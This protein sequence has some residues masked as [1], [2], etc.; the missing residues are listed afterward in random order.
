MVVVTSLVVATLLA[1]LVPVP[2]CRTVPEAVH[3]R[4]GSEIALVWV[5]PG[6]YD[7]LSQGGGVFVTT[8]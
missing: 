3:V 8:P 7:G 6:A 2:E 1:L 5:C 4:G